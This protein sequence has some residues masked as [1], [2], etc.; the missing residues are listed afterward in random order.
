MN[1]QK[2]TECMAMQFIFIFACYIALSN[3]NAHAQPDTSPSIKQNWLHWRGP[4][5]DGKAASTASPPIRWNQNENIA[6]V[7]DLPGE[8][9]STPIVIDEKIFL[10]TAIKTDRKS[11]TPVVKDERA[12]TIPEELFYEFALLCIDRNSG[13]ML[14]QKIVTEEVPHEG[15]HETNTY[16]SGSP[17]SDGER[18]YFSFGSRGVFCYSLTGELIWKVNLGRMRTRNG[19]GEAITPAL[20]Q[21]SVIINWDQEEN[22]YIVALDKKTGETN[23]KIERP[24]EVT[25]WNTPIV[26]AFAGAEQ[27]IVNGTASV[28][29]YA[30]SDGK[31]LWE[32]GGQTV[33]AIPSPV[34]YKD[35]VICMS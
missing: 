9:S 17:I 15:K 35:S 21:D 19:W 23:W 26:A 16:A 10:L 24:N 6:W 20:T 2:L 5:A 22:S 18:L 8:G 3:D 25:S 32:C 29:S 31:L 33:N 34:R 14:W 13:E 12:K 27:V 28:K 30:A 1:Y 7:S 11:T 4:T